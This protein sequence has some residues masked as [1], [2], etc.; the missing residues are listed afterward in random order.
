MGFF[1]A[2]VFTGVRSER[3]S[4]FPLSFYVCSFK[5]DPS[6]FFSLLFVRTQVKNSFPIT[7]VRRAG[8]CSGFHLL[9]PVILDGLTGSGWFLNPFWPFMLV[10]DPTPLCYSLRDLPLKWSYENSLLVFSSLISLSPPLPPLLFFSLLPFPIFSDHSLFRYSWP[11]CHFTECQT[12]ST[13][14]HRIPK[15]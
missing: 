1:S 4:H 10:V 14:S 5:F 3:G 11:V 12:S 7:I 8:Q 6:F 13:D 2:L 9:E 15:I